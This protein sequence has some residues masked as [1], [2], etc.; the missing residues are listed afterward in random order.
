MRQEAPFFENH[1]PIL[2]Y[3]A[4]KLRDATRLEIV[5]TEA[6]VDYGVEA[7]EYRGGVV[8]VSTRVGAF[9]YVLPESVAAAREAMERG[10]FKPY[11]EPV[12]E[13]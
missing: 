10:G 7:D 4:K 3:I 9:F 8:F 5:L 6:G 12:P 11:L 2:I 13:R 1:D